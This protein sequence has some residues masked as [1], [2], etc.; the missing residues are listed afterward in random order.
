MTSINPENVM[1]AGFVENE[2]LYLRQESKHDIIELSY[3]KDV[4]DGAGIKY[5]IIVDF[6]Q[7]GRV[8]V[9][10]EFK[11]KN[12]RSIVVDFKNEKDVTIAEVKEFYEMLWITMRFHYFKE[13]HV[14][15][16]AI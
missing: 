13:E 8:S 5:R 14:E 10:G 1:D 7:Q 4:S 16:E 11:N 9:Q 6:Y 2:H 15:Q 3:M 12:G